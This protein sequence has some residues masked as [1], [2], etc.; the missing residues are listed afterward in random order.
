MV[1]PHHLQQHGLLLVWCVPVVKAE[2]SI[3]AATPQNKNVCAPEETQ[4]H[5]WILNKCA[6]L[7]HA[8]YA[9]H[10]QSDN[11]VSAG[12]ALHRCIPV[13]NTMTHETD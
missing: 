11:I 9:H 10:M 13:T 6:Q 7:Y 4:Q 3:L 1:Q 12:Q 8:C 2:S 5:V